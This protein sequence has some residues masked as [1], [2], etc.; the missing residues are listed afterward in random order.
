MKKFLKY[1]FLTLLFLAVSFTFIFRGRLSLYYNIAKKVTE[2]KDDFSVYT[3]SDL[4]DTSITQDPYT[5]FNVQY[6]NTNGVPLTLDIYKPKETPSKGSP[7]I[8]YVHGGS[9][10]YG[11]KNIPAALAPALDTFR[12]EGYT[13]ISVSYELMKN[14]INFDKQICDVKDAI[15]WIYKNKDSYNFNTREIGLLGVSAGAH[16][17][18]VASYSDDSEFTDDKILKEYPSA[19]KYVLDFFGPTDL[20]T[21]DES[22]LGSDFNVLLRNIPNR[23]E[24]IKKYSAINY[25]KENL[26]NTLVIHSKSDKLV[27]Y[28]N[29]LNLY[30][31]SS[32]LGNKIKLISV[33]ELG[34]DLSNINVEDASNIAINVLRFLINNS[35]L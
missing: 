14:N 26:P 12:G 21:L 24:I 34:H 9:Y 20:S 33:E 5:D 22:V 25:V 6:K 16:L 23:E 27:P 19:I 29:S 13:I 17:S 3:T 8:L 7:V 2:V 11:D 32:S 18:L 15:R 30:E 35:P 4:T 28:E 10:V 1:T 31:K